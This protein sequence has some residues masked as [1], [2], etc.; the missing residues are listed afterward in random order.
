MR[1]GV[2]FVNHGAGPLPV[3]LSA[4]DKTHGPTRRFMEKS[5]PHLLGLKDPLTRPRAIVLVSAHWEENHV[6]ISCAETSSLL[7]DYSGFP[8]EAY[9]IAYNAK[10][11]PGIAQHIHE[12]LSSANIPSELNSSRGWDHG[13]FIPMKLIRPMGDIPIVQLSVVAGFEPALHFRIGQVIS[14]LRDENIAIVGSGAT[15]H[16][17]RNLVDIKRRGRKF[18]QALKEA[19]LIDSEDKRRDALKAWTKLPYTR[20]CHQRQEHLIPLM[21]IAGAAG[22]QEGQVFDVDEG[23]YS[24]FVWRD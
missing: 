23:I 24:S 8:E 10:G 22:A 2:I 15:F 7:Y 5:I 11:S 1:A 21:V 20:D 4:K 3:L 13:T 18:N 9:S 19:V 12:L 17:S 6:G 16:P 14:V